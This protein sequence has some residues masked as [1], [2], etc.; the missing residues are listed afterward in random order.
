MIMQTSNDT[1]AKESVL[2]IDPSADIRLL[3]SGV[4]AHAGYCPLLSDSGEAGLAILDAVVPSLI[5]IDAIM[6]GLSGPEL[7]RRIRG[8]AALRDVPII[9]IGAT[10]EEAQVDEAFSAGADDY[11]VKPFDRRILLAR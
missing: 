10:A 2:V 9:L 4:L 5:C 1:S 3:L 11:V 8:R 6:P 7:V